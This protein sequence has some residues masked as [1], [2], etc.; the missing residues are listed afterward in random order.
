VVAR[1]GRPRPPA[2]IGGPTSFATTEVGERTPGLIAAR[3]S[4]PVPLAARRRAPTPFLSPRPIYDPSRRPWPISIPAHRRRGRGFSPPRKSPAFRVP[5][6][7]SRCRPLNNR[8]SLR[9]S[10]VSPRPGN[11]NATV[12]PRISLGRPWKGFA[13]RAELPAPGGSLPPRFAFPQSHALHRAAGSLL[14]VAIASVSVPPPPKPVLRRL[15]PGVQ[16]LVPA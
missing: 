14:S 2:A 10:P 7:A 9:R 8:V 12:V 3:C 1:P 16:S 15:A 11:T 5:R 4:L 13:P 6:R